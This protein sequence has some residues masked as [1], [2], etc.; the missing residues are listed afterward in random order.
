[1]RRSQSFR[2]EAED[3]S[4]L[5]K[6]RRP[7]DDDASGD[8][9][10]AGRQGGAS[11][12]WTPFE[13]DA[14]R[15]KVVL[16]YL[17]DDHAKRFVLKI[18]DEKHKVTPDRNEDARSH[19]VEREV[20]F[21]NVDLDPGDLIRLKLAGRGA[22]DFI[23]F[24]PLHDRV[25][26]GGPRSEEPES[27]VE[28]PAKSGDGDSSSGD[29]AGMSAF[30][31]EVVSLTNEIRASRGLGELKADRDLAEAAEGHSRDMAT[32]NFF[33][34]VGSDGDRFFDR[35][36]D[37]GYDGRYV[38]ENIAA[39]HDTPEQVVAAWMR[40]DGH[41]ANILNPKFN[42]IGVGFVSDD[43]SRYTEYWTQNFGFD[44]SLV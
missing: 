5:R 2:L 4:F 37:A 43:D 20:A 18:G 42:E 6:V 40:S 7:D 1:M 36:S 9:F 13:G 21:D 34:H 29:R 27:P 35:T 31:M 41:R 10:L 25:S 23:E 33:G 44:S 11:K 14:G 12:A 22:V 16:H 39:G 15:Y 8:G 26:D 3:F 17:D 24:V 19:E 30:E 32:N 28:A 38:G